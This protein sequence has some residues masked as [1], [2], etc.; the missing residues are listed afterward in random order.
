MVLAGK[1]YSKPIFLKTANQRLDTAMERMEKAL[2]A[3]NTK[4]NNNEVATLRG[5]VEKLTGINN[6]IGKRLDG[7]IKRLKTVLK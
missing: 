6:A 1:K 4:D 5:E 2:A 3:H 7:A